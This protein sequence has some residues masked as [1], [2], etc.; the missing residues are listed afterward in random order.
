VT[1]RRLNL[2]RI[3]RRLRRKPTPSPASQD[4]DSTPAIRPTPHAR[5]ALPRIEFG[6]SKRGDFVFYFSLVSAAIATWLVAVVPLP[7]VRGGARFAAWCSFRLATKYRENVCANL[8]H[9]YDLPPDAPVIRKRA[10]KVFRTNALNAVDLLRVPHMSKRDFARSIAL[11]RGSWQTLDDIVASGQGGIILTAHLGP[12]DMMGSA[13]KVLGYPLAAL[14]ARTT[15]RF[16]FHAVTFLRSS[17]QL[18]V[19]ETSAGGLR[20]MLRLVS[21]GTFVLLLSDRD[22]FLSGR[23]TTFFG[24]PTTLPIGS[25]RLA[26]DTGVPIIPI[27]AYRY[28][29]A[30]GIVIHDAFRVPVSDD[31][32][33]DI[34]FA[35]ERVARILEEAIQ[36]A[37]EQ[38]ALFQR[39]WPED[40]PINTGSTSVRD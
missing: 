3:A 12:F 30:N 21:S 24:E 34:Q 33:A 32:D 2:T 14:T 17:Q 29:N 39:V 23:Q 1:R 36:E 11:R 9:I 16:A 22:F 8:S 7:I 20:T 27:F 6:R 31:R 38:W 15:S 13:L 10:K 25:V 28:G 18:Q 19:I 4:A 26:R 40:H 5:S 37:P 35:L